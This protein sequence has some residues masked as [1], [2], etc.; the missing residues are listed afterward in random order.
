MTRRTKK[1]HKHHKHHHHKKHKTHKKHH[2]KIKFKTEKCAPKT[3]EDSLS[4]TCYS[5]RSLHNLK[6]IWNARHP[7]VPINSNDPKDIWQHL[8][9]NM[10]KT[11]HK[12][13]CW[14]RDKM[15]K[16]DLPSN[17]YL[18]N[19]SPKQPKEWKKKPNTWLTSIEIEQ[20]MKQYEN[21]YRHFRFL[22]PSPIDYDTRKLH[23]E[24]VWEEICNFS[25]IDLKSKGITKVGL[26]FNL[27]PHYKEGSH[28][29]AMFI[30]LRKKQIYYFDSYGDKIPTRLM[31]FVRMVR[32]QGRHLGEKYKF[33]QTT[34]RHQYLSTECGMYSLFFI[35]SLLEGKPIEYFNKRVTD[36]YMRK[37]RSIY[38]NKR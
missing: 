21:K 7:D 12:E 29:V 2:R 24:C 37:L 16:N 31:K 18:Q 32:K 30:N 4:F 3:E 1:R 15:I 34:R 38:F 17:F 25:L 20:L 35:I 14:L 11:C 6:N 19:F 28:W 5:K 33:H 8:K 36:K 26:I 22:G 13:S 27:D 9:K 23:N 10:N